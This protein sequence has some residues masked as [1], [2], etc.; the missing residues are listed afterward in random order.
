MVELKPEKADKDVFEDQVK[1]EAQVVMNRPPRL[2]FRRLVRVLLALGSV[3]Y[4]VLLHLRWDTTPKA[5]YLKGHGHWFGH[6]A[7]RLFL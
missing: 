3:Y 1:N 2:F 7:E 6:R 4:L 5:L